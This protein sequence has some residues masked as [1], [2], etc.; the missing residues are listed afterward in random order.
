MDGKW[1]CRLMHRGL[2]HEQKMKSLASTH[3][4]ANDTLRSCR[5]LRLDFAH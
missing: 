1:L 5:P 2:G 3:S 4:F